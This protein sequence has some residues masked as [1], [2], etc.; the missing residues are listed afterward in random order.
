[1]KRH[2]FAFACGVVGGA[3]PNTKSNIHPML[4]G[5][6][7]ALLMTKIVFGDYDKGY[8]WTASDILFLLIVGLEG[9]AGALL[10]L[11]L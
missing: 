4:L 3:I 7:L 1:M 11:Q 2:L 10:F 5:A 9:A 6:I 8:Q